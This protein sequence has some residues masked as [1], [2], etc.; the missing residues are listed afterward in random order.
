[1]VNPFS[2]EVL[3][4]RDVLPFERPFVAAHEWGHLAGRADESEASFVGWL[5][6]MHGP[7]AARYS[8][9]ISLY[10]AIAGGLP[11]DERAAVGEALADG[12]RR[13]LRALA[14]RIA[15]R[16]PRSCGTRA[17]PPTIGSS[18]PTA[19][20]TAWPATA[21]VVTL[22]LGASVDIPPLIGGEREGRKGR[23]CGPAT[24]GFRASEVTMRHVHT[25]IGRRP[26]PRRSGRSRRA[27][28]E[29][30]LPRRGRSPISS[31][32][33]CRTRRSPARRRL[34]PG[35]W[36]AHVSGAT[37]LAAL[38]PHMRRFSVHPLQTFT[39]AR[40]AEQLDGAWAAVTA[41]TGDGRAH[42]GA[43]WPTRSASGR[44]TS[45]TTRACSI[46]PAPPSRR[47]T[48]S[49]CY[50]AAARAARS[51]RRAARGARAAD[52]PHDRQRLRADRP[53]RARRLG[54][55]RRA[56]GGASASRARTSSRC[57]AP[58][59]GRDAT[60]MN[61]RS[62][63][64]AER[65]ARARAAPRRRRRIGLV[66]TMGALHDGHVA[67]F[68]GRAPRADVVVASL[69]VNPTQ[70]NDPAD[71]AAYP[72]DEA[73]DAAARGRRPASTFCSRRRADEMY[74]AGHATVG[75]G[76]AAPALGLEGDHRPGH[77]RGV[78][79]VCLKLFTIVGPHVAFFGQKDAQ[80]V[81]V[82]PAARPRPE[83]R[84][85]DSRRADRARRRRRSRCR[86]A[87]SGCRRTS[88]RRALA[89]PRALERRRSRRTG[90][91]PTPVAAARAVLA[92]LEVEYVD[93]RRLR[94]TADARD[95]GAG[96]ARRGSSIMCRWIDGPATIVLGVRPQPR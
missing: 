30:G 65:P 57:T 25:R 80:Q 16:A 87:T 88:A 5:A 17:R 94:R 21:L 55:R 85:R 52:A 90:T 44:S 1:M 24:D 79:T 50:R 95:R 36:I 42:A 67:L 34:A 23:D 31:C 92:G 32:S 86:R 28:Q 8:A 82:H 3:V 71:L 26:R 77:F 72:R 18:R 73:R 47:T 75:R 51:G 96:R 63:R 13:D 89:I 22:L 2:L 81:A 41:E 7:P 69:F 11:R 15:R 45:P 48:S 6:C 10:G 43:G 70:F 74:P 56:P 68:R 53:D 29:R 19:S 64:I 35:P 27:S 37:P 78:A 39:R 83:P 76:R 4:N 12:P 40:G 62:A 84:P 66:P 9:W 49:R 58:W 61:D 54:H 14:E 20:R 59:R 33:P 46:T 60:A 93:G 38:D 91:A